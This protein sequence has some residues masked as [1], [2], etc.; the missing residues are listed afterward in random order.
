MRKPLK[1][2]MSAV[3]GT[4]ALAVVAAGCADGST[5]I[6]ADGANASL[7]KQQGM[8]AEQPKIYIANL[9]ELNNSGV[10]GTARF[11][12]VNGEFKA[13]IHATGLVPDQLHP[14]HIHGL[15]DN[16]NSVCPP[17]SAA[18]D[19]PNSPSAAT[20][21]DEFISVAEGL[22]FY[23]AVRVPLDGELNAS[24]ELATFP[25]ANP[26]GIVNYSEKTAFDMLQASLGDFELLPL[27][28][29]HVVLHGG[30]VDNGTYVVTLPVAC[31]QIMQVK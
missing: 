7:A 27:D 26:A 15:P 23:G 2:S 11:M 5:P 9:T 29:K 20:D 16:Q 3:I 22:P 24:T 25:T 13:R 30:L 18:D 12:I 6:A 28:T 19:I 8:S 1:S 17:P 31:G 4:V 14:Q 21:P 10:S